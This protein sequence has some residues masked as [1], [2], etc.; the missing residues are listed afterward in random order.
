MQRNFLRQGKKLLQIYD[1]ILKKEN[2]CGSH[3][4]GNKKQQ[5]QKVQLLKLKYPKMVPL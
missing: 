4:K 1:H 3:E 5:K 2:L